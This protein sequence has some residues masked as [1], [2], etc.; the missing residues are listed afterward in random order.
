MFLAYLGTTF[1]ATFFNGALVFCAGDAMQGNEPSIKKG[2]TAAFGK[3]GYILVWSVIVAVVSVII[4][5][6]AE[7]GSILGQIVAVLF[8]AAWT[9]MTYFV[10]PI[11]MFE[12]RGIKGSLKESG[13]KFRSNWGDTVGTWAGVGFFS[14]IMVLIA[15]VIGAISVYVTLG[16]PVFIPALIFAILLMV[17]VFVVSASLKSVAKTALYIY[18]SEGESP[19]GFENV[20]FENHTVK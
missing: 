16:T 9:I 19:S 7:N 13:S 14:A 8:S 4:R 10:L 3:I 17:L 18:A 11:I 1:V 6:I 20:D 5:A 2:L 12:D 15:V